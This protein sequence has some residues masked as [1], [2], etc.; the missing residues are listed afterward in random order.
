MD[1]SEV[2]RALNL[3]RLPCA[4]TTRRDRSEE[5]ELGEGETCRL[6]FL[7]CNR[8]CRRHNY[9]DTLVMPERACT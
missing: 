2:E 6:I 8:I 7:I 5:T 3:L 4:I 1:K 9:L